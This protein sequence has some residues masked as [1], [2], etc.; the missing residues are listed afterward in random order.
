M[1][2]AYFYPSAGSDWSTLATSAAAHPAVSITAI[3]NP[4]NGNFSSAD[5]NFIRAATQLVDAGGA[6]L[7]YVYTRYG[8]GSRSMADIKTNID[9]Y[10]RFYGRERIAGIFLDEMASDTAQLDFYREIY[11]Y[12]KAIDPSLRVVG[13][14]GMVPDPAFSSVADTLVIFEG[15]ATDYQ[16]YDPRAKDTW[17]YTRGNQMQAALVHNTDNCTAMQSVVQAAASARNNAG[18][19]YA[20]DRNFNYATG[21]GNPWAKLPMYWESL[22]QTVGAVNS[23]TSLPRC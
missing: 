22:V 8:K 11:R 23:G 16:K 13:N 20:T 12:I 19:V 14:P 3:M 9:R 15:T 5:T 4:N 18:W 2:P 7:G 1:V 6:V 17:L 21:A 10:L